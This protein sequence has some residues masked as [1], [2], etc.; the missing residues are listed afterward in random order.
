M[1][2]GQHKN[3]RLLAAAGGGH[4]Q[5][6]ITTAKSPAPPHTTHTMSQQYE[7]VVPAGIGPGQAFQ[8]NIGG[9]LM[10]I[11]C[12]ANARGGMKPVAHKKPFGVW[13]GVV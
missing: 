6:F 5:I 2:P 13:E 3:E 11:N 7:V 9:Q 12:P 1:V 10:Q 4:V 8:I